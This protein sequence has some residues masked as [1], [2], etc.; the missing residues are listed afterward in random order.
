VSSLELP[1]N[2]DHN[3][4]RENNERSQFGVTNLIAYNAQLQ[5]SWPAIANLEL[6]DIF[7]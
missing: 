2:C 5:V 3:N 1:G 7:E 6:K 4:N